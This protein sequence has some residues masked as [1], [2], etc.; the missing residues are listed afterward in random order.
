MLITLLATA[1]TGGMSYTPM[2]TSPLPADT[3]NSVIFKDARNLHSWA[4]E[5]LE[6]WE[7][8][9][10]SAVTFHVR[11]VPKFQNGLSSSDKQG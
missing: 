9:P 11:T 10:K 5:H 7:T 8:E 6:E 1:L 2:A 3:C 4:P